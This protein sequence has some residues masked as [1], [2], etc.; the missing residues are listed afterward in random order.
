L[1]D[2]AAGLNI[3]LKGA[4]TAN[5]VAD[6][7]KQ[8]CS[9]TKWEHEQFIVSSFNHP[10]LLAFSS[11]MPEIRIGALTD[12]IPLGYA[13]F[14]EQ[15]SAWSVHASLEFVDREFVENAHSRGMKMFV[16]TVNR[17]DELTRVLEMGVDGVF[18][19]YPDRLCPGTR[20]K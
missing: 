3:E 14:A 4:G 17:P 7:L 1:I 19:D 20:S 2:G 10:E 12:G 18:T 15:L 9:R 11:L 5:L 6:L 8:V 16:Y 13:A